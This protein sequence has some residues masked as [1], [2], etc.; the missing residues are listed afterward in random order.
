MREPSASPAP[1]LDEA[2]NEFLAR[3]PSYASTTALDALRAADYSRIDQQQQVY[4]DYTGGSLYGD[5][6]LRTHFELLRSAVFGNPHSANPASVA[7]TEH[8]ERAR[9]DSLYVE[10]EL[11]LGVP[12]LHV[13]CRRNP[14]LMRRDVPLAK[15]ARGEHGNVDVSLA[16]QCIDEITG[17]FG[18][19]TAGVPR[20]Q[21][22]D[23]HRHGCDHP[24][25]SLGP[26]CPNSTRGK[27]PTILRIT[28]V[29]PS[30]RDPALERGAPSHLF[31]SDSTAP[32]RKNASVCSSAAGV[33][34]S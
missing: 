10:V 19:P 20:C 29:R 5:S 2:Y 30:N 21:D 1:S 14:I 23:T 27:L 22:S 18:D 9:Q 13:E 17:V 15:V 24:A 28:R 11:V 25:S 7:M 16:A 34:I 31:V 6:Q 12:Y 3:Y 32:P 4:L 8:V 33:P 26:A